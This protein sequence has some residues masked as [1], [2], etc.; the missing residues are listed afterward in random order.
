LGI[1]KQS[2]CIRRW[3]SGDELTAVAAANSRAAL[4][5]NERLDQHV[6]QEQSA[7][8]GSPR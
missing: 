3:T 8:Q 6:E 7:H 4:H 1:S 5:T 2:Y